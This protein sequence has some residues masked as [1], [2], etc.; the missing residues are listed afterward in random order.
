MN[1]A[2]PIQQSTQRKKNNCR[3]M[4]NTIKNL[5]TKQNKC[6]RLRATLQKF[7]EARQRVSSSIKKGEK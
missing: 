7:R 2:A 4:N 6:H 3:W 5:I 1:E